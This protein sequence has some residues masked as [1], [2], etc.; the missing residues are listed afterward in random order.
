MVSTT[1]NISASLI[2]RQNDTSENY[3][4][5]ETIK[6]TETLVKLTL[7]NIKKLVLALKKLFLASKNCLTVSFAGN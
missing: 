2:V 5:S 1:A 7:R 6:L 4:K 3:Y